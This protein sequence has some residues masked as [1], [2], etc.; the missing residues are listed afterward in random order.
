MSE[1]LFI[2]HAETNMAGTF[3]GHSDPEL[4][5]CGHV[6]VRELIDRLRVDDI[7]AVYTSD[8]RRAKTTARAI[9]ESFAVDCHVRS[10]LREIYFGEWEGHAWSEIEQHDGGYARR[11]VMEYPNL[12]ARG[13]EDIRK[14]ERRIL[15]EVAF[16]S[17]QAR[18]RTI[19]V[20]TH[21]GPLR[22]VLCELN[23]C[24][25]EDAWEQTKSYCSIVRLSV[26]ARPSRKF[27]EVGL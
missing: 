3:C 27:A 17:T 11:W 16:L 22:S 6:Q 21:A 15:D 7:D 12:P 24:S 23:G 25:V 9:A 19:A 2:R 18:G 20:V 26:V 5:E 14:F 4:N 10:A 13:G 1:I 8:L